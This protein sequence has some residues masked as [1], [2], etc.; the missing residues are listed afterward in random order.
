MKKFIYGILPLGIFLF[1]LSLHAQNLGWKAE[2]KL[3]QPNGNLPAAIPNA[4]FTD[5]VV[6]PGKRIYTCGYFNTRKA[7]FGS[8]EV[9]GDS[10]DQ[11]PSWIYDSSQVLTSFV[12]C[13]DS[14]GNFL[15]VKS[16]QS[17]LAAS[18]FRDAYTN[19]GQKILVSPAEEVYVGGS[20]YADTIGLEGSDIVGLNPQNTYLYLFK[21]SSEGAMAWSKLFKLPGGGGAEWLSGSLKNNMLEWVVRRDC[22]LSLDGSEILASPDFTDGLYRNILG[23]ITVTTSGT[24]LS[25]S[26]YAEPLTDTATCYFTRVLENGKMVTAHRFFSVSNSIGQVDD[27]LTSHVV[28]RD[29]NFGIESGFTMKLIGPA[30][31]QNI[32]IFPTD[33]LPLPDGGYALFASVPTA[34]VGSGA[35]GN[36][37]LVVGNDTLTVPW[38]TDPEKNIGLFIKLS[39]FNCMK[40]VRV[41]P[42]HIFGEIC[43]TPVGDYLAAGGSDQVGIPGYLESDTL[44]L[45]HLNRNGSLVNV[46][47]TGENVI[48]FATARGREVYFKKFHFS[49]LGDKA[50]CAS[51]RFMFQWLGTGSGSADS[52]FTG[53]LSDRA[54]L[55]ANSPVE[56]KSSIRLLGNP[57]SDYVTIEGG[58]SLSAKV[59][60]LNSLGQ[61]MTL[62][63]EEKDG[64]FYV[65]N[66]PAGVY[67]LLIW[68]SE[69]K[70]G[71]LNFVK[72]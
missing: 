54:L 32:P 45:L 68:D 22:S 40:S 19:T 71:T 42:Y 1:S 5:L 38:F 51:G 30:G 70:A 35:V 59:E 64:R 69:K 26:D 41:L 17:D 28:L 43:I 56:P 13:Q 15:W 49:S 46:V 16:L 47:A 55:L 2:I 23:K 37:L 60:I 29:S 9:H 21:F 3:S 65:G 24:L 52:S 39:S 48:P 14:T 63:S 27:R 11:N 4:E 6:G 20:I 61:K 10:I 8:I 53:C 66:V 62:S 36:E 50:V 72:L 44:N 12:S 67:R 7:G 31:E 57:V 33:L 34:G 18:N 25:S 58:L